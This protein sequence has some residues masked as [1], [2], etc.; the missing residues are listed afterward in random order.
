VKQVVVNC[1]N[2][3]GPW[4][5]ER[6]KHFWIPQG[7]QTIGLFDKEKGK[8]V[9]GVI[10]DRFN[11]ANITGTVAAEGKQWLSKEFLWYVFYYPFVQLKCKRITGLIQAKNKQSIKFHEHLGFAHEATLK[12]AHPDGDVLVYVMWAETC[13]WLQFKEG[14]FNG[15]RRK[16]T[17]ST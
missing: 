15:Q 17:S 1:N 11:G 4:V 9:A 6:A 16:H 13:R 12:D 10:Y 14:K 2:I 8:L 5:S 7:A 3:V